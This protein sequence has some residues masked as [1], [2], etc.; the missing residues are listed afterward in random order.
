MYS[1]DLRPSPKSTRAAQLEKLLED[2]EIWLQQ[3]YFPLAAGRIVRALLGFYAHFNMNVCSYKIWRLMVS[4]ELILLAILA[5]SMYLDGVPVFLALSSLSFDIFSLV[6]LYFIIGK[7][8]A[9][10]VQ[11]DLSVKNVLEN[12]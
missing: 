1:D 12:V 9:H 8:I 6:V 10:I 11:L 2:D 5:R 4:V 3:V 7:I